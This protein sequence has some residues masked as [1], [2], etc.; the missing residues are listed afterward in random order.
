[1]W[2]QLRTLMDLVLVTVVDLVVSRE[3]LA[4]EASHVDSSAN[5]R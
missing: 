3:G 4:Q 5:G 2:T 1:M